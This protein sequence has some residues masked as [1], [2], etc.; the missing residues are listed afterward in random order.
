MTIERPAPELM[1]DPANAPLWRRR[2][3][4]G[5]PSLRTSGFLPSN[6]SILIATVAKIMDERVHVVGS[7]IGISFKVSLTGKARPGSE[8]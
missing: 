8:P 2:V 3:P 4:C 5:W 6:H 1:R 7:D